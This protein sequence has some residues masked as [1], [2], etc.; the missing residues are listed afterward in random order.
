MTDDAL[1]LYAEA[2]DADPNYL[3][4]RRLDHWDFAEV[5]T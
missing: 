2:L 4:L 3:V 5:A 1:K